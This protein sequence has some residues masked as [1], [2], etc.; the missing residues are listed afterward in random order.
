M[1]GQLPP[2]SQSIPPTSYGQPPINQQPEMYQVYL[3]AVKF[4][5]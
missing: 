1:P 2:P 5:T 3:V 4:R